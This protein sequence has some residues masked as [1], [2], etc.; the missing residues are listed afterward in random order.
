M[1]PPGQDTEEDK[2]RKTTEAVGDPMDPRLS[3]F[4]TYYIFLVDYSFLKC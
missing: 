3:Y 1:L 2:N 4:F